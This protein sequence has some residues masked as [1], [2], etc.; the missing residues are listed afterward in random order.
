MEEIV[1]LKH[2]V[3]L[4]H[5]EVLG[6]DKRLEDGSSDV[7]MVVAAEGVADVVQQSAYD[8][9]FIPSVTV[10]ARRRLQA[11]SQAVDRE[12]AAVA[13]EDAQVRQHAVRQCRRIGTEL[14]GDDLPVFLSALL[15]IAKG[16]TC[17]PVCLLLLWLCAIGR[18][19][20]IQSA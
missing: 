10:G 11:V 1:A 2:A 16:R 9:L 15:Y 5:R 19:D 20:A 14:A 13:V 3:L 12:S 18:I 8:V 4:D 17:F 7:G 6:T